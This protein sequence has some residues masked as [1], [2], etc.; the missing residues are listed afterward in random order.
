M[1]GLVHISQISDEHIERVKDVLNVG[2]EVEARVVK[3]DAAEHRIGLSVK[4]A[5]VADDEFEVKEDMLEG[6]QSGEEPLIFLALL[7]QRLAISSKSGIPEGRT[8]R[9]KRN[10]THCRACREPVRFR[11]GFFVTFF[12]FMANCFSFRV[13]GRIRR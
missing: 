12:G 7:I 8:L 3:V 13:G 11:A 1:D 9:K 10:N 5:Q 2:D 4:A 6:L